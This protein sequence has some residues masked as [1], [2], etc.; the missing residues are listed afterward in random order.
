MN[1]AFDIQVAFCSAILI[2]FG[3]TNSSA[4]QCVSTGNG[5]WNNTN[6]WDCDG[7][8][9]VPSCG[10][11]VIVLSGDV[12]TVTSQND[13]TG[14]LTTLVID[15]TG[16]LQFSNGNK[17]E[18]PC[19]SLVSLQQG[20]I[21][22]KSTSGGGSSTLISICNSNVWTAADGPISGPLS[23]G[24]PVL[25]VELLRFSASRDEDHII[26]LSWSTATEVNNDYFTLYVSDDMQTW[27]EI[28]AIQGAGNSIEPI[29]Y[30]FLM[31]STELTSTTYF[32]LQQ[33]DFDG[34][35]ESLAVRSVEA[36]RSEMVSIAYST[37]PGAIRVVL[38][39]RHDYTLA[40]VVNMAGQTVAVRNITRDAD[41]VEISDLMRG[42]YVVMLRSESGEEIALKVNL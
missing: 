22:R 2:L 11:T 32:M 4:Q 14:C 12:V 3:I 42:V 21:I 27:H 18:L 1:K 10:D 8:N 41:R 35:K 20:G 33:T 25:P 23:F 24:G 28:I 26:R 7:T 9:R 38:N 17:L 29:D 13:Y 34:S 31:R 16:I 6:T 40:R 37:L 36:P 15:V 39:D 30:E 5:T 19:G